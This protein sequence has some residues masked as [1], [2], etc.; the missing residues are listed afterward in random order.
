MTHILRNARFEFVAKTAPHFEG[1]F[2]AS[3]PQFESP[4]PTTLFRRHNTSILRRVVLKLRPAGTTLDRKSRKT[5]VG[6]PSTSLIFF[7]ENSEKCA[8]CG[9]V[10]RLN[11]YAIRVIVVSWKIA[12]NKDNEC[13]WRSR[14]VVWNSYKCFM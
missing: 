12:F 9:K 13:L 2:P 8:A 6:F 4:R 5:L 3:A 11:A 10:F 7:V 1:L 14:F